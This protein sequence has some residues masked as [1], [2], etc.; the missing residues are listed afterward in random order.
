MIPT[1]T[2]LNLRHKFFAWSGLILIAFSLL[3]SVLYY[4][5]M[6]SILVKEALKTSEVILQE[7]EAIREYVQQVLRPKMYALHQ[8]DTF[9]LEAMSTTHISLDIM[10]RFG[11]R[12]PG[13]IFRRV[14]LNPLNPENK[15][16]TFEEEMFDWFEQD[17]T[18]QLWQGIV[19]KN[20]QAYFM[21]MVPEYYKASCLNCHGDYHDAPKALVE[22]YGTSGG[23]RFQ[24]GDL[25]G[26]NSVSIPVTASLSRITRDA[27]IVFFVILATTMLALFL[28][29]FLFAQLVMQRL[30]RV[31]SLLFQDDGSGD[32][33]APETLLSGSNA[34]ELDMLR[35]SLKTLSRYVQVARKGAG[36]QP[37]FIG[38]YTV[39][40]PLAAGTLSWLYRGLDSEQNKPVSLKLGFDEVM[41]NPIYA[42]CYRSELKIISSFQ[43]KNLLTPISREREALIFAPVQGMDL[44][45]WIRNR[46]QGTGALMSMLEQL[47]DLVAAMHTSGVVHH[48]LRPAVFLVSDTDVLTLF[49]MGHAS[50]RDLSDVILS[51]GLGPQGD[52]RYMAPELIQGRRGDPRSDIYTLGVMLHLIFTGTLPFAGKRGGR[53]TWLHMK[54]E[55]QPPRIWKADLS[56]RM[57]QIIIKAMA[58]DVEERYQ[59]VEDLWEELDNAQT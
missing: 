43:H 4:Q 51:S 1:L 5:H 24:E 31:N 52:F 28:L 44:E 29:N 9:I 46:P 58:W 6:R 34:D 16:D 15:A 41:R 55:V 25:G 38:P 27:V 37:D 32:S 39:G 56:S 23:Y 19:R 10:R 48:D 42:S 53:T 40:E 50:W 11:R 49:D 7:V 57:E 59:W 2:S 20:G 26:I 33:A 3:L 17:P 22:H 13:Y 54:K 21:S 18:Q 14:S 47:F 8:K 36:L 12:M 35:H 30:N 45:Q